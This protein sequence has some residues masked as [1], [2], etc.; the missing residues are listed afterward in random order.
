MHLVRRSAVGVVAALALAVPTSAVTLSAT[1]AP[2]ASQSEQ[3]PA[4]K[5]VAKK[6]AKKV[7]VGLK[8][9]AAYSH[10]GQ[11]GVKVTATVTKGKKKLK[12]KVTFLVNGAAATTSK[13]RKGKAAY[14]LAST[15]PPGLYTVTAKYKGK[16]KST[17]VRVY[18]S[19]ISVSAT[20]FTISASATTL[21]TLTGTVQFKD[22]PATKGY[23]DIYQN[24][25]VKD[26]SGS[27]DYCCMASVQA[28]GTFSFSGY[29][30]LG[31]VQDK[32]PG[33]YSYQ[34]FYTDDAG[35]DDYIYSTPITVTV[36]P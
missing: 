11:P 9:S 34:A 6:K 21:P 22:A 23:V 15:T 16:K 35:F 27:P 33:T 10:V 19:A 20:T 12:G 24:G 8:R 2:G 3:A 4:A 29:T 1:A 7:N 31:K 32:G 36:T 13:L 17:E 5:L 26:G 30:F 14:R 18:S 28:G 25:N